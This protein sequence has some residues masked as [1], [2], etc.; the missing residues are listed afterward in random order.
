MLPFFSTIGLV[1][2]ESITSL[3]LTPN[4][5]GTQTAGQL[6]TVTPSAPVGI[7]TSNYTITYTVYNGVC[8]NSYT[9]TGANGATNTNWNNSANWNPSTGFP[10]TTDN[11]TIPGGLLYNPTVNVGSSCN[12]LTFTT[13]ISSITI[14][15]GLT[16]LVNEGLTVNS[17]AQATVTNS[18]TASTLQIGTN[19]TA[20]LLTNLGYF[21]LSG[22]ILSIPSGKNYITNA[23]GAT[24]QLDG[25]VAF[26]I[27]GNGTTGNNAIINA[28]FF[29][30]GYENSTGDSPCFILPLM[31]HQSNH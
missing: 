17:D 5:T 2:G 18:S 27:T 4:P 26:H 6:Y 29:Y 14:S 23:N 1:N 25:G 15:S 11:A 16:L 20:S 28:G 13:G 21:H 31:T 7:T 12:T 9:W 22:G 19:S 24:F 10:G 3:T 30:A 8:G